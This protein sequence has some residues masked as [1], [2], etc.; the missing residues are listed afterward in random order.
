RKYDSKVIPREFKEGDLV[1]KS[2]MGRDKGGKLAPNWEGPFRIN[3]KFTGGAYRLETLQGE[4]AS[5]TWN[6]ANLRYYYS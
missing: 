4:V 1:L 6:V 5:R 2:P 3:E